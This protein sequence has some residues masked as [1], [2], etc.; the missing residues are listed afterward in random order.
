MSPITVSTEFE[1]RVGAD[2][3]V[4]VLVVGAVVVLAVGV[5]V[6]T[7]VAVAVN[8]VVLEEVGKDAAVDI[9]VVVV[10]G[11]V[12]V[13]VFAKRE[14]LRRLS[15]IAAAAASVFDPAVAA[16]VPALAGALPSPASPHAAILAH[17]AN[18]IDTL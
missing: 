9:V 8:M 4:V 5:V 3:V 18:A 17:I 1:A 7:G 11:A 16:S 12:L 14:R 13:T 15:P 2:A 10:A 6:V